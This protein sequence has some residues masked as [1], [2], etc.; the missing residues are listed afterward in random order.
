MGNTKAN[1]RVAVGDPGGKTIPEF[2]KTYLF[3]TTRYYK[4][5]REGRGPREL[6]IGNIVRITSEAE[7]EW[8][9]EHEQ[10]TGTEARLIAREREASAR[11][12]RRA[13]KI[14]AASPKH[15]CRRPRSTVP[16]ADTNEP[17]MPRRIVRDGKGA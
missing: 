17:P 3:G 2:C 11:K 6:R 7:A 13:G 15:A 1:H 5:R 9:R 10:P 12:S 4:M 16:K 8:V 14:A